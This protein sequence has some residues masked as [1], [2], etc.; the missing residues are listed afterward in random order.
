MD[1]I[2]IKLNKEQVFFIGFSLYLLANFL[3]TTMFTMVIPI[4]LIKL[5]KYFGLLLILYKVVFMEKYHK[6]EIILMLVCGSIFAISFFASTY[7]N[8]LEYLLIIFGAKDISINKII[9]NFL[10]IIVSFLIITIISSKIG[11]IENLTYIRNNVKRQSFG[12]IY[13]TDF[14][15]YIFYI[16]CAYIALKDGKL[17]V[18][19]YVLIVIVSLIV[20][21]LTNARLDILS[22]FIVLFLTFLSGLKI[23][24]LKNKFVKYSLI[25]SFLIC[26]FI[27]IFFTIKYN[28]T[29][30]IYITFDNIFSGRL[31]IGNKMYNKYGVKLFGQKIEDH[32]WG[33]YSTEDFK[34]DEYNF[35]DSTYLRIILKFGVIPFIVLVCSNIYLCFK[36]YNNKKYTLLFICMIISIN[37]IVAQHYLDISY[38]FLI[39]AYMAKLS[40]DENIVNEIEDNEIKEKIE[41]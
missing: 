1:K 8:L 11:L 24:W 7:K 36:F 22:I 21:L 39:I 34:Y 30:K 9:K 31:S 14:A 6:K 16:V 40:L 25:Y 23:D 19:H 41:V 13:P 18:H 28:S 29:N 37:S 38:N 10:K 15:A 3:Y 2:K 20:Y 35:I 12:I 33:K 17:K 27:A 26:A 4:I 32:G 5:I